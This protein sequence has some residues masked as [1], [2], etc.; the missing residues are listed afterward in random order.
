MTPAIP[1]GPLDIRT[2]LAADRA[3]PA[4]RGEIDM[5]T[6]PD[7]AAVP[8]GVD[9]CAS[10]D[11][12]GPPNLRPHT[13]HPADVRTGRAWPAYVTNADSAAPKQPSLLQG[14]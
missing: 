10:P 3:V 12:A 13:N 9:P 7:L 6:T 5:A 1:S 11:S 2:D 8:D 4:L 14:R